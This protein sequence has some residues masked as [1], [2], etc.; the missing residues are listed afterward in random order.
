MAKWEQP[1]LTS[2]GVMG[3]DSFAVE[4]SSTY[5]SD[6]SLA[7]DATTQNG[8]R[9]QSDNRLSM[10]QWLTYYVPIPLKLDSVT[11]NNL[12]AQDGSGSYIFK[13][14]EFLV[15]ND[16]SVW[17]SVGVYTNTNTGSD[18][19]TI[20]IS[21][22]EYYQYFRIKVNSTQ[23]NTSPVMIGY[24]RLN[25]VLAQKSGDLKFWLG[26]EQP[27]V[28]A[29]SS[30]GTIS[31]S[32]Y[33]ENCQPYKAVDGVTST[34]SLGWATNGTAEG[35]WQWELPVNLRFKR[36][37][38]VNRNSDSNDPQVLSQ[39]CQ[40]YTG[41]KTQKLGE[42]FSVSKSREYVTIECN[43]EESNILYF[44]KLGGLY[45][46]IGEL[47]IE[48]TENKK[49]GQSIHMS[50][51]AQVYTSNKPVVQ[52]YNEGKLVWENLS[53]KPYQ[54]F[55]VPQFL[56]NFTEGVV[57]SS[58]A[59]LSAYR[60]F[61]GTAYSEDATENYNSFISSAPAPQWLS[62]KLAEPVLL[63]HI[64]FKNNYSASEER[65]KTAQFFADENM[66]VPLTNEFTAVNENG[67]ISELDVNNIT[68]D[69]IYCYLK[70][71]YGIE[72]IVGVGEIEI[73]AR[74]RYNPAV[75]ENDWLN[76]SLPIMT[77][78]IVVDEE[79]G[80]TI[81]LKT[82]SPAPTVSGD[83]VDYGTIY[84]L[85]DKNDSEIAW[86]SEEVSDWEGS[87]IWTAW[88]QPKF[89]GYDTWGSVEASEEYPNAN[90]WKAL[91]QD[92]FVGNY[93]TDILKS[94]CTGG[95]GG[96][97][98]WT[99]ES[100]LKVSAIRFYQ[101]PT[102]SGNY[103]A[104]I[105]SIYSNPEKTDLIGTVDLSNIAND[106]STSNVYVDYHLKEPTILQGLYL[107]TTGGGIGEIEL[108]AEIGSQDLPPYIQMEL[109][110]S[111]MPKGIT[112]VNGDS[113]I[114]SFEWLVSSNDSNYTS[115]GVFQTPESSQLPNSGCNIVIPTQDK[116]YKFH[117]FV[118]RGLADSANV[119]SVRELA[120]SFLIK[121]FQP[122]EFIHPF[123]Q[124]LPEYVVLNN[125]SNWYVDDSNQ[126]FRNNAISHSQSTTMTMTIECEKAMK[127]LYKFSVSSEGNFD[128]ATF[129][130]DG[131]QIWRQ[132]GTQEVESSYDL[133]IGS[134]TLTFSYSKDGSGSTGSDCMFIH[135][136]KTELKD[137]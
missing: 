54:D 29:N 35:W 132:S 104:G 93:N 128:W 94:W 136:L 72:G 119:V 100:Y 15:S 18:N 36:L 2:N 137:G 101:R 38:F 61:D 131:S 122:L 118:V 134:H 19:Y 77:S 4:S 113:A 82:N 120:P 60:A 40:F 109:S 103:G 12:D 44:Y 23:G 28:K 71:G 33:L 108:T 37:V 110:K 99:F 25:G 1:E 112:I 107:S 5:S 55:V 11:F 62:W 92:L 80:L 73:Q 30:Y 8:G 123:T 86:V 90:A 9:W 20:D 74:K 45:S 127:L 105:V 42:G 53:L 64:T 130:I 16:N 17:T 63:K 98:S 121:N 87:E 31:A 106:S 13:D 10:P 32:S 52:V 83:S 56:D 50:D 58:S 41:T 21:T 117:R 34:E 96:D 75:E 81:S 39:Q 47:I 57:N 124:D 85:F 84:K 27:T 26:W 43:G 51:V 135:Y 46:G 125:A 7:Y 68:T 133:S 129:S 102:L 91:D 114:T 78:N 79:T 111:V 48:A 22:Q 14:F 59:I 24:M 97:W 6:S 49:T 3:G 66:S 67:G 70:E 69:T 115:L 116:A 95:S 65:T 126:A 89:T 76:I 88:T